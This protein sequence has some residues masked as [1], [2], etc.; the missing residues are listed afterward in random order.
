MKT[1]LDLF[2]EFFDKMG[3]SQKPYKVHIWQE[4]AGYPNGPK[5]GEKS[6]H[7]EMPQETECTLNISQAI[8]CFDKD[9]VYLGAV[10]DDNGGLT[11]RRK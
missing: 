3:H 11:R 1:D 10:G 5:K 4:D 8:F 6:L 7:G 2:I 9:G